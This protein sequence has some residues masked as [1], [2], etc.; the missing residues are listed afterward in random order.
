MW[1]HKVALY[2][3]IYICCYDADILVTVVQMLQ[4]RHTQHTQFPL[5]G[6]GEYSVGMQIRSIYALRILLNGWYSWWCFAYK[7]QYFSIFDNT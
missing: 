7:I 5:R 4:N 6:D 1:K 2:Y 3:G